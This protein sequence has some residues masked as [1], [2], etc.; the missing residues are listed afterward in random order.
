MLITELCKIYNSRTSRKRPRKMSRLGYVTRGW[1]LE[2]GQT[3]H[4]VCKFL[5]CSTLRDQCIHKPKM[6]YKIFQEHIW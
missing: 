4:R 5:A 3:M 1:S 2:R 6:L